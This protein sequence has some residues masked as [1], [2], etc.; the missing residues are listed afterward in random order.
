M[1]LRDVTS[2][3]S[4]L[5]L[6]LVVGMFNASPGYSFGIDVQSLY[7]ATGGSIAGTMSTLSTTSAY[8]TLYPDAMSSSD[9]AVQWLATFG[10]QSNAAALEFVTSRVASGMPRWQVQLEG[11]QFLV[12]TSDP[13][14]SG[15]Q[16]VLANKIDVAHYH[17]VVRQLSSSSL[18]TLVGIIGSVDATAQSAESAKRALDNTGP[19]RANVDSVDLVGVTAF[20]GEMPY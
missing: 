18:E 4:T 16:A 6:S 15:A 10:L 2:Q 17:T 7:R 9:F 5:L 14:F 19:A 20:A 1:S 8:K 12:A 13:A 11:L 3:E